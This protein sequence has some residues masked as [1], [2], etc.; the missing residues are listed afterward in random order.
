M[1]NFEN[2]SIAVKA[3]RASITSVASTQALTGSFVALKV[4]IGKVWV[5]V[6][7]STPTVNGASTFEMGVGEGMTF[8]NA[9]LKLISD[10]AGA[11]VNYLIYKD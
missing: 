7:G 2:N 9:S 3:I 1:G 4:L 5:T 10:A 11:V 6:D 8:R